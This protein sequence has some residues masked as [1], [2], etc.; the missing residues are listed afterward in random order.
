MQ[1]RGAANACSPPHTRKKN[2]IVT[3]LVRMRLLNQ[4]SILLFTLNAIRTTHVSQPPKPAFVGQLANSFEL[5]RSPSRSKFGHSCRD[6]KMA[7]REKAQFGAPTATDTEQ[8]IADTA[9]KEFN[10]YVFTV[11]RG[12]L[13]AFCRFRFNFEC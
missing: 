11:V 2:R 5:F 10:W 13:R 4:K 8:H 12:V 6:M 9:S 1:L 3:F 7:L